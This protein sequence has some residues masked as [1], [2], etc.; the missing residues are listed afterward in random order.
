MILKHGNEA[1]AAARHCAIGIIGGILIFFFF[2]KRE[3]EKE[4]RLGDVIPWCDTINVRSWIMSEM[5]WIEW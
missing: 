3:K 1:K 2:C 4:E 5:N